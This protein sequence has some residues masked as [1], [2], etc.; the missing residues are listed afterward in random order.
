MDI[1]EKIELYLG[2]EIS[3]TPAPDTGSA[4]GTT[5]S[6]VAK[7]HRRQD[8]IKKKNRKG[9]DDEDSEQKVR[10]GKVLKS[11]SAAM[12]GMGSKQ[13]YGGLGSRS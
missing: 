10:K 1:L 6:K 7:Y 2:E 3:G 8:V 13:T 11:G 9:E 5:T 12:N 4:P